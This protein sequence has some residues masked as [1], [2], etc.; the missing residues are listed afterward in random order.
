MSPK[1]GPKQTCRLAAKTGRRRCRAGNKCRVFA[2]R[3]FPTTSWVS[4]I[5]SH[6]RFC[7]YPLSYPEAGWEAWIKLK[8]YPLIISFCLWGFNVESDFFHSLTQSGIIFNFHTRVLFSFV[9]GCGESTRKRVKR[10]WSS[11]CFVC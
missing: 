9:L 11:L 3:F 1:E 10:L 5:T 4:Q 7:F 2:Y 6:P 8:I